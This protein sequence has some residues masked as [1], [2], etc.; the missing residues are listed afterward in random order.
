MIIVYSPA[1]GEVEHFDAR[2]LKVSEVSIVQRTID[3]TWREIQN[4][5]GDG[6]LEAMRGIAWVIKKRSHPSLRFGDFDPGIE[7]L[8]ARTDREETERWAEATA[9]I[10]WQTAGATPEKVVA[11]LQLIPA[12]A[13]D[14]DHAEALVER[15]AAAPK[16]GAASPQ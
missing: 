8:V 6:D 11:A 7:E 16:A 4:G 3:Q 2:S 1:G 5:L 10:V 13:L 9:D 12:T 14:R 15:L